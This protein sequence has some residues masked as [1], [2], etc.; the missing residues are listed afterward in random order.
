MHRAD[1]QQPLLPEQHNDRSRQHRASHRSHQWFQMY[2]RWLLLCCGRQ[3]ARKCHLQ[4]PFRTAANTAFLQSQ[5]RAYHKHH[6]K[7]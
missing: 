5:S 2:H 6:L 7:W 4:F 3:H 1:R